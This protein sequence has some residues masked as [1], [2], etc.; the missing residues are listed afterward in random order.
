MT[1]GSG[2]R[3][4]RFAGWIAPLAQARIQVAYSLP[5]PADGDYTLVLEPQPSITPYTASVIVGSPAGSTSEFGPAPV[6]RQTEVS[7]PL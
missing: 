7:A 1:D 4:L 6:A 3:F 5:V 2:N